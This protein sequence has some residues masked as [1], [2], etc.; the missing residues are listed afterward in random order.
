MLKQ[1]FSIGFVMGLDTDTFEGRFEISVFRF[2]WTW[3][4][5]SLYVFK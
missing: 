4:T 1:K 2:Y 5:Y 3:S